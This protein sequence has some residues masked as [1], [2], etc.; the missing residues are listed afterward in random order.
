LAAPLSLVEEAHRLTV[1]GA[2][3]I[4]SLMPMGGFRFPLLNDLAP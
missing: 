1:G 2:Q 4:D 3:P